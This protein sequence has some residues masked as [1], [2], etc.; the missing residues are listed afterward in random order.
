MSYQAYEYICCSLFSIND[1]VYGS[2]FFSIT[3]LHGFHVFVGLLFLF[4]FL[5]FSTNQTGPKWIITRKRFAR[6]RNPLHIHH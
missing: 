6:Y 3:G 1:S 5:I 4:G 2:A